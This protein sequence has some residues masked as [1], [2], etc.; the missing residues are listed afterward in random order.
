[1][2]SVGVSLTQNDRVTDRK[3]LPSFSENQ[4]LQEIR[5]LPVIHVM[6]V[7]HLIHV[8][9]SNTS[10]ISKALNIMHNTNTHILHHSPNHDLLGPFVT[11]KKAIPF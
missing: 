2:M 3:N 5:V 7:I 10:T 6:C 9:T 11:T 4:L 8:F 1:M